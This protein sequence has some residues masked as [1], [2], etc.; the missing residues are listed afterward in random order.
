MQ[1]DHPQ[2]VEQL[3]WQ[4]K[5]ADYPRGLNRA[6]INDLFD[7]FPPYTSDEVEA[8]NIATNVAFPE[9]GPTIAHDARRQLDNSLYLPDPLFEVML[10]FGPV[11]KR[12]QWQKDITSEINKSIKDSLGYME[13]NKSESALSVSHGIGPSVWSDRHRWR[14]RARG[15]EDVLIPSDTLLDF[16]NLPF[17]GVYEQYTAF[18]LYRRTHGPY[19]DPGWN[20]PLVEKC[21]RWVDQQTQTLMS[22]S[23][24]EVWSPEKM[25]DRIKQD[26][27]LYASDRVPTVDTWH[28]YWWYDS[29]KV[30]GWRKKIVLDAWGEPGVGGAGGITIDKI[31]GKYGADTNTTD[32]LYDSKRRKVA[33]SLDQILHFQFANCSNKAPFHYHSVRSLGFLLYAVCHLQNRLRCKFNDAVFESLMQYFRV[34]NLADAERAIHFNL[35]DK[36]PIPDGLNFVRPDERWKI[37]EALVNLAMILNRESVNQSSASYKQDIDFMKGENE[38]A[39][40]TMARVNANAAMVS[41]MVAQAYSYKKFQY[42]EICRRFCI[43][44]SEDPA[45]RKFR[46]NVLRKGVPVEALNSEMWTVVPVKVIGSGN[47]M[48]QIGMADKLM[49]IYTKLE[50]SAQREVL[51][52]YVAVNS[53]DYDMAKRLVPDQPHVSDSIHDAQLSAGVMLQGTNMALKE[54]VNHT[55]YVEAMLLAMGMKIQSITQARR[56]A[57]MEELNG[58]QNLAGQSIDGQMIPGNGIL[59]HIMLV[60]QDAKQPHVKGQPADESVKQQVKKYQDAL[61]ELMNQVKAMAQQAMEG[62]AK[63]NGNGAPKLDP[64]DAAK[65]EGMMLQAQTKA[66]LAK[67][68]HAQRTAQRQLQFEQS[69]AQKQQEHELQMRRESAKTGMEIVRE[70]IKGL[71]EGQTPPNRA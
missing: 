31:P 62:A 52:L 36:T 2:T 44:N 7:G 1:F 40:R 26:G 14:P 30:S 60:A 53:D 65:V 55:E 66:Q 51:R 32:F 10:D 41:G 19:V 35:T 59:P 29:G 34:N 8:N 54:G 64:K 17:F 6:K 21:I 49:G 5:L 70:S 23:W 39:T 27:G 58:L 22:A 69:L 9:N 25:E 13:L 15:I 56:P 68:S 24:P 45:V 42:Q 18:E 28:F 37:D 61:K 63:Q 50:P 33:D 38:T 20:M 12:R 48:V 11:W 4:M 3:I 57:T 16:E 43:P 46:V 71:N 47:K 67:Q